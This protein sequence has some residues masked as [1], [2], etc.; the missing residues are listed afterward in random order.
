MRRKRQRLT[1]ELVEDPIRG[2]AGLRQS[3]ADQTPHAAVVE[4][5]RGRIHLRG[6]SLATDAC[7]GSS[8]ASTRRR[9]DANKG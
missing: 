1:K 2:R 7:Y 6:R 3:I 9:G 8:A 5:G 4:E